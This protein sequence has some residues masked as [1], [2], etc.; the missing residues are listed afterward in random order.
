MVAIFHIGCFTHIAIKHWPTCIVLTKFISM[1]YRFDLSTWQY[2]FFFA[3]LSLIYILRRVLDIKLLLC[4]CMLLSLK[5]FEVKMP[6]YLGVYSRQMVILSAPPTSGSLSEVG[7][8]FAVNTFTIS[9][10]L[11]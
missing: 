10:N 11:M 8:Y 3:I 5:V 2:S 9:N 1:A 7:L 6:V 4:W